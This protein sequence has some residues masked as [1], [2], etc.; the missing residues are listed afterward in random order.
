MGKVGSHIPEHGHCLMPDSEEDSPRRLSSGKEEFT[1]FVCPF[2]KY[3]L[4][5]SNRPDAINT[6]LN[7]IDKNLCSQ[8]NYMCVCVCRQTKKLTRTLSIY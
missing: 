4:S 3:L 8:G 7:K 2:N 1:L 6:A 5:A